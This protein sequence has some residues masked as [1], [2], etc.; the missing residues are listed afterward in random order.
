LFGAEYLTNVVGETQ[1]GMGFSTLLNNYNHITGV[2]AFHLKRGIFWRNML[3]GL[4]QLGVL[5]RYYVSLCFEGRKRPTLA[6]W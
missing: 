3:Q 6:A 1:F 5:L 4:W 2:F